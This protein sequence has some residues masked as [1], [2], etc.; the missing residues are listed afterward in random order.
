MF[1]A[2]IG[3]GLVVGVGFGWI[4]RAGEP[5]RDPERASPPAAAAPPPA[6][7]E[8]GHR[9]RSAPTPDAARPS[10]PAVGDLSR[11]LILGRL[12]ESLTHLGAEAPY[13][14]GGSIEG[15]AHWLRQRARRGQVPAD[16]VAGLLAHG[17]PVARRAGASLAHLVEPPPLSRLL[18]IARADPDVWARRAAIE[19]LGRLGREHAAGRDVVLALAADRDPMIRAAAIRAL[20]LLA[21]TDATAARALLGAVRDPD[22]GVRAWAIENL[23][24]V[25]PAASDTA[26]ELLL[27][28]DLTLPLKEKLA[29]LILESGRLL[30]VL[31]GT[32]DEEL[33]T[34]VLLHLAQAP[35][36]Y[37]GAIRSLAPRLEGL[38]ASFRPDEEHERDLFF[39]L[40]RSAGRVD[41]VEKVVLDLDEPWRQR[42]AAMDSLIYGTKPV[43]LLIDLV[44]KLL[45]DPRDSPSK[46]KEIVRKLWPFVH[47]GSP[48][49]DRA[50]RIAEKAARSDPNVWVRE[51]ARA[52][53]G[54][55]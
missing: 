10:R 29:G 42:L 55:E 46:R 16:L 21:R 4:L 38:R 25:G 47:E 27:E 31:D 28:G 45:D 9:E 15:D 35:E 54:L 52:V 34:V 49:R 2:G 24:A 17:H 40:A 13:S 51:E 37:G 5:A 19:A 3:L 30:E 36:E 41:L 20:R 22:P 50:R 39:E 26:V 6:A 53:A 18:E 12:R 11:E 1:L 44:G 43:P 48:H 33:V 7:V 8:S 32:E 14:G 23:A